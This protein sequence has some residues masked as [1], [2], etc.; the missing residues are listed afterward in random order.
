MASS[1][2]VVVVTPLPLYT[3]TFPH[4]PCT[5]NVFAKV[6]YF[7]KANTVV[8]IVLGGLFVLLSKVWWNSLKSHRH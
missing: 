7:F 2:D 4:F 1:P 8:A 3:S 5:Q 6:T